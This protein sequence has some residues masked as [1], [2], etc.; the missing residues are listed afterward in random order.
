[1]ACNE[2]GQVPFHELPVFVLGGGCFVVSEREAVLDVSDERHEYDHPAGDDAADGDDG[3]GG[4]I[5]RGWRLKDEPQ[6]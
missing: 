5:G 4:A 2:F 6:K 3:D 1:M